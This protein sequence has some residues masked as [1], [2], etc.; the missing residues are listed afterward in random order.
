MLPAQASVKCR[1]SL[2]AIIV[3]W[4]LSVA[5]SIMAYTWLWPT[6]VTIDQ[7]R[8]RMLNSP[9]VL[10]SRHGQ[11]ST[12]IPIELVNTSSAELTIHFD[13]DPL[14]HL[15]YQLWDADHMLLVS[16][17]PNQF[18]STNAVGERKALSLAPGTSY[19]GAVYLE[20]CLENFVLPRGN[21]QMLLVFNA[22]GNIVT[23]VTRIT[24][25]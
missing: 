19:E 22:N 2:F 25:E 16:C 9:T 1:R 7:S 3:I 20:T 14:D 17:R 21:Y 13:H 5:A 11:M 15:A 24:V 8:S 4:L 10:T 6:G 18:K 23:S 12:A